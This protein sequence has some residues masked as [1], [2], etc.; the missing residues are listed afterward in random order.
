MSGENRRRSKVNEF[1]DHKVTFT[2]TIAKAFPT[3]K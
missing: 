1:G 2:V 3:G